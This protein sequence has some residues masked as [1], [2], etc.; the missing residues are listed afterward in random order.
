MLVL[1]SISLTFLSAM[2]FAQTQF[3]DSESVVC[4]NSVCERAIIE[5]KIGEEKSIDIGGKVH[6]I[7]LAQIEKVPDGGYY[8]YL[9]I[10]GSAPMKSYEAQQALGWDFF[11]SSISNG[12]Y[13][14]MSRGQPIIIK[15]EAGRPSDPDRTI[16]SLYE[17][18]ICGVPDCAFTVELN[19]HK[20]WNLIPLYF[21][22]GGTTGS[23]YIEKA[24][25]KGT[26]KLQDFTVI[27]GYNPLENKHVQLYSWGKT[28]NDLSS[29][30]SAFYSVGQANYGNQE[31]PQPTEL[32]TTLIG[33][34]FNSVWVYSN[35]ECQLSGELPNPFKNF[36]LFLTTAGADRTETKSSISVPH[37]KGQ[38]PPQM[39]TRTIQGIRFAPG[40]NFFVGSTDM[41]G[42]GFDEIRGSCNIEKAYTFDAS[43][44]SWKQ[45]TS[46]PGPATNFAFKAA[47]RCML[48][49]PQV[50]PP[51][52]P[53]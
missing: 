14:L 12:P 31:N 30:F 25:K 5:L 43:S 46:G 22:Q 32:M 52:V 2:A 6:K 38:Q 15:S 24:L 17:D 9:S 19:V 44:Q 23:S 37:Q 33:T 26:C 40:W 1:I 4:G 48:G 47:N 42:K 27:Y 7:K 36:L 8:D 41:E 50:A 45:L 28:A 29:A 10:D 53:Q 21:L 18:K 3:T 49:M 39:Q 34:P 11:S 51:E 20:K 35:S 13:P 16:I